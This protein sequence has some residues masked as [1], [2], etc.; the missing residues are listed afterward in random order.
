MIVDTNDTVATTTTTIRMDVIHDG[1]IRVLLDNNND[2]DGRLTLLWCT[3][4][5]LVLSEEEQ[6]LR[7]CGYSRFPIE[8]SVVQ[9]ENS[10]PWGLL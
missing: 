6:R 5:I 1:V 10:L 9:L 2:D 4:I 7:I 8:N 3:E